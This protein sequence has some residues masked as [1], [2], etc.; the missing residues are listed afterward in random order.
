VPRAKFQQHNGQRL[1]SLEKLI[2]RV[3]ESVE[4]NARLV[5]R[6][7]EQVHRNETLITRNYEQGS[8]T[9]EAARRLWKPETIE[10]LHDAMVGYESTV[11]KIAEPLQALSEWQVRG[12][13]VFTRTRL[14]IVAGLMVGAYVVRHTIYRRVADESAALGKEVLEKNTMNIIATVDAVSRDPETLSVLLALLSELLGAERTRVRAHAERA[15]PARHACASSVGSLWQA[16]LL[17]LVQQLLEDTGTRRTLLVRRTPRT[18]C[19]RH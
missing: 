8:Q 2:E 9:M 19:M 6:N 15:A 10:R 4:R 13:P 1:E 14:A 11:K 7:F 5:E 16:D 12:Q 17:V 18:G 3:Q